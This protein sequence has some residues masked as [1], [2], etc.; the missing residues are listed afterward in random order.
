M[1]VQSMDDHPIIPMPPLTA[2]ALRSAVAAIM[3]SRLGEM[4]DHMAEAVTQAKE[5]ES[6]VPLRTFLVTWGTA[7]AIE[8]LPA[9]AAR[10]RECERLVE[11]S[12]D[13]DV[14]RRAIAEI[15]A[16]L[17]AARQEIGQ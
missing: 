11:E 7:V 12:P 16:I 14:R 8:R 15:G 17:D 1:S 13:A 9:R 4:T 3:P 5:S 10:L 2:E 6:T